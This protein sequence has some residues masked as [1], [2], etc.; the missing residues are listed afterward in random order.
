MQPLATEADVLACFAADP[1]RLAAL[2]AAMDL[3]LPDC[4]IGAGFVRNPVW[5]HLHDVS[6]RRDFNDIDVIYFDRENTTA[7]SDA[8][9]EARLRQV[10]PD[11]PWSVLNMARMHIPTGDPPYESAIHGIGFWPETATAVAVRLAGGRLELAAPFGIADLVGLKL[12]PTSAARTQHPEAYRRRL[13]KKNWLAR[14]PKL[15]IEEI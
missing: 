14:W 4:W 9:H 12:R 10:M 5:D 11:M 2:R 15:Q 7:A 1:W 6:G 13:V 8:G 3:G